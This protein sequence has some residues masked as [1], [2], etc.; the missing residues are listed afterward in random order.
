M[1]WMRNTII[2]PFFYSNCTLTFKFNLRN[3]PIINTSHCY[4][5][6]MQYLKVERGSISTYESALMSRM[7]V[8]CS[9]RFPANVIRIMSHT[10]SANS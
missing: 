8:R 7:L 3:F 5:Y 4:F 6:K 2:C 10:I 1:I 9:H